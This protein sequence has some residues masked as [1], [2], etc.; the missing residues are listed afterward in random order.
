[1][2]ED[3]TMMAPKRPRE[4]EGNPR[5]VD[6]AFGIGN[7]IGN[8][9][10]DTAGDRLLSVF[11]KDSIHQIAGGNTTFAR[12]GFG[13]ISIALK[14]RSQCPS[15]KLYSFAAVKTVH[16]AITSG[17]SSNN[18][19]GFGGSFSSSR[20]QQKKLSGELMN[21]LLALKLLQPHPNIVPLVAVYPFGNRG[22][23]S[24]AF[25][26][27]PMDLHEVLEV[28]RRTFRQPLAFRF[29]RTIFRDVFNALVHCHGYGILHRDL[30]PGNL[31]VSS[32]GVIRLCD[33]GLA[34]PFLSFDKEVNGD[35]VMCE[36]NGKT[37]SLSARNNDKGLCTLYYRPP[38]VLLGGPSEYPSVDSWSA[39][40]VLAELISGRPLWTGR[41][42]IDQL[43]LVFGSLGTPNEETWPSVRLLPDYGKLNFGSKPSKRWED[44]LPRATESPM[45]IDLLSNLLSLNPTKRHTAQEALDHGWLRDDTKDEVRHR[46]LRDE[47][48][49][50]TS[51]QIP[52][53]LF[54]ENRA[55]VGKLGLGIAESRRGVLS[56]SKKHGNYWQGP[57]VTPLELSDLDDKKDS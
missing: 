25:D 32:K 21:E 15:T 34:K 51:L 55:L 36:E 33:F 8:G 35:S 2:T 19:F 14:S 30:K 42:V 13:E 10:D 28:R 43:S 46:E 53:L 26:Y 50:P 5:E 17:G 11:G 49:I 48:I 22:A 52:P 44:T 20:Q 39:G 40:V 54:P 38:E 29:I 9:S 56:S 4:G 47:L 37:K 16:K 7:C 31:L 1:M 24:L 12:G 3:L 27:C 41:N 23:L 45:L 57:T 6:D 18:H